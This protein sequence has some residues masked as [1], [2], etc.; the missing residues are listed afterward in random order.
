MD[1]NKLTLIHNP[2][3]SK[4]NCLYQYLLDQ[5]IPF[6]LR[7]YLTDPL[8]VEELTELIR[9]LKRTGIAPRQL[10]RLEDETFSERCAQL[11]PMHHQAPTEGTDLVIAILSADPELLQRPVLVTENQAAIGRPFEAALA[12][13]DQIKK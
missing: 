6:T 1:S 5:Q 7:N 2:S 13:L 9:K 12:F 10:I 11:N 3:C 4:S 8:T